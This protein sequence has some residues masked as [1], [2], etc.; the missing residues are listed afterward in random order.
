MSGERRERLL[1]VT[2]NY[3]SRFLHCE[4]AWIH[5]LLSFFHSLARPSLPVLIHNTTFVEIVP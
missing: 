4:T 1:Y 2:A 5:M 3:L